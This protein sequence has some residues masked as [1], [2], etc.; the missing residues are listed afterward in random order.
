MLKEK[1]NNIEINY[2]SKVEVKPNELEKIEVRD[3]LWQN[4]NDKNVN[5]IADRVNQINSAKSILNK[6][7]RNQIQF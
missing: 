3:S 7:K 4:F 6:T 2:Q 5:E 1:L